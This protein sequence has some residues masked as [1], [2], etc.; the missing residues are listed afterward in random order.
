[1][2]KCWKSRGGGGLFDSIMGDGGRGK[3]EKCKRGPNQ[4][5][6]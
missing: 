1:M 5:L 2:M 6:I 3:D 4:G